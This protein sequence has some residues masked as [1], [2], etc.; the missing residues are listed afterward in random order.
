MSA[1][2]LRTYFGQFANDRFEEQSLSEAKDGS[3]IATPI[4]MNA[5]HATDCAA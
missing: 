3:K 4:H 1:N 5:H 2:S